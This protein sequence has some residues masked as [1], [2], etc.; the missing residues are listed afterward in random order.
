M[1]RQQLADLFRQLRSTAT[2]FFRTHR[3]MRVI[4]S[5]SLDVV[6]VFCHGEL[7]L[8]NWIEGYRLHLIL[9]CVRRLRGEASDAE[10]TG[11]GLRFQMAAMGQPP[12]LKLRILSGTKAASGDA[13]QVSLRGKDRSAIASQSNRVLCAVWQP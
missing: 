8:L 7:L 3:L 9:N 2:A 4:R 6:F 1:V 11:V 13:D 5:R 10:A 12:G